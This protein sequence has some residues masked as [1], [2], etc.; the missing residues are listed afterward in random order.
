[1]PDE[2]N[3]RGIPMN[4]LHVIAN[5]KPA[6]ESH[7]KQLTD[8]FFQALRKA[9][10]GAEVTEVDLNA[11]PP[12][13]YGYDTYRYFWYPVFDP[14]Y[15]A[16]AAEQAA[17]RYSLAQC[18]IFKAADVLVLTTPMWNFGVPAILK[19]WIDQILMPNQTFSIG[20]GGVK[21]LHKIRRIVLLASSGGTYESGD[22]RDALRAGIKAA[23]GFAGIKDVDVAWAQGQNPFFFQ[24][25]AERKA[26]AVRKAEALGRKIAAME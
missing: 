16:S 7:S 15:Q 17:V 24:D 21:P 6:A 18:R 1:M 23:F 11:N 20:P 13:F 10:A 8:A 3:E 4:I 26:K 2:L 5:P 9:N 19:A 25:H 12:P 22:P 14:S